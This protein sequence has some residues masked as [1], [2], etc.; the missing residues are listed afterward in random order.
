MI[1]LYCGSD[2]KVGNSRLQ[3]RSNQVWR[4]RICKRCKAV[5]TT[6]EA[7]DLS[8]TLI[9]VVGGVPKPFVT[10]I[11]YTDVLM[12]MSHRNNAYLDAREATSTIIKRLLELPGKPLFLPQQI[13]MICADVLKKLDR[14]AH[15]RFVAEHPSLQR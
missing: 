15:L 9:V 3:R 5:F 13:S 6:H 14:R 2:T 1:C 7:I 4:R 11:L 10:D 12:S 8:S